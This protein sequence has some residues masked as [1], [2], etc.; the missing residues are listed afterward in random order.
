MRLKMVRGDT[1]KIKFQLLDSNSQVIT[2]GINDKLYFTVKETSTDNKP[3]FQKTIGNGIEYNSEYY[4]ITIN[5]NDTDKLEYKIYKYDI[6]LVV[7]S[8][9]MKR[10][11]VVGDLFISDEITFAGNE[12]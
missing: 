5:S 9:Q 8:I 1:K 11:L 10:T 2:L 12:V 3:L 7:P 6:E 4:H